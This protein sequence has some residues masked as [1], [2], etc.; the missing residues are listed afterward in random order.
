MRPV[1]KISFFGIRLA[2]VVL[3]AYWIAIFTGTHLP[4]VMDFSPSFNDK[5]KHLGAFFGLA[6][7]LCY[8]SNSTNSF[9]RF[10]TIALVCMAYAAIDEVTQ[11][12]VRGR[13]PDTYD[14]I[15]DSIGV[16]LAI[17][18]YASAKAIVTLRRRPTLIA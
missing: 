12:F 17:G 11:G 1:S 18:C 3:V 6:T 13:T 2:V 7:L 9:R 14:F 5:T 4:E 16:L 10:G 8:V 15:A